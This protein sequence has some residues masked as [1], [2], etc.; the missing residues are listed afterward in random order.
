MARKRLLWLGIAGL[1]AVL[2]LAVAVLAGGD[3]EPTQTH[4]AVVS[5]TNS[6]CDRLARD[7]LRL[8]PPPRPYDLQ[9]TD[10]FDAVQTNVDEAADELDALRPPPDDAAALDAI[11]RALEVISTKLEQTV[12]AASVD[13]SSEVDILVV[14]IRR[15]V[16]DTIPHERALGVCAGRSSLRT[17]IAA[18][19][20]RTRENPLTET[21][22]LV[23]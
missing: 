7:N 9:S 3:D 18:A 15:L 2:V 5:A 20:K 11:V 16:Q 17:S 14:E 4:A 12:A 19:V 13:Q 1:A 21:G 8:R 10:F 23:P 6:V 22:P